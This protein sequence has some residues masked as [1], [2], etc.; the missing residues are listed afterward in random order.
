MEATGYNSMNEP[1]FTI[2][3]TNSDDN[4]VDQ[5]L[6]FFREGVRTITSFFDTGFSKHFQIYVQ[7]NRNAFDTKEQER[8][9]NRFFKSECWLAA[10]GTIEG[11]NLLSPLRWQDEPCSGRYTEYSDTV[12]TKK[13]FIHEMVHVFHA[14]HQQLNHTN[15]EVDFWFLEG[16]AYYVSGQMD[17]TAA[18]M[19]QTAFTNQRI[20]DHLSAIGQ[21]SDINLRYAVS[22]SLL[23]FI[24]ATYGKP[25]LRKMLVPDNEKDLQAVM[26]VS[27]KDL[28]GRWKQTL[29]HTPD[30]K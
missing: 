7:P 11:I 20:P 27:E 6:R 8:R 9:H 3:Y 26:P 30:T 21:I 5:Y 2:S 12:K 16:I 25:L 29:Q 28:I 22:G 15:D 10:T 14:Q 19:V 18:R 4:N 13:L 23:Q 24:S 17:S 1:E